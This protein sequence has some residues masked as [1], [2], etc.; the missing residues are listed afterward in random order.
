MLD[1][2]R[3]EVALLLISIP[4]AVFI[5]F[6]LVGIEA[7]CEEVFKQNGM[8]NADR[9]QVLHR[10]D[11]FAVAENLVALDL[12]LADL[13]LR[14]LVNLEDNFERRGRD[15]AEFRLDGGE[16]P[17]ALGKEFLQHV[18]G[19]LNLARIVLRFHGETNFPL[20]EPV[21]NLRDRNGLG[22]FVLDRAHDAALGQQEA[23]D[24]AVRTAFFLKADIIEA[25]GIP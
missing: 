11:H 15:L 7:L 4:Y 2:A 5:F 25:P 19:A 24:P 23:D 6:E 3:R 10:A 16:L 13:H 20:F 17:A 21:Q 14:A 9:S 18:S 22:A 8:R 1:N 12:D